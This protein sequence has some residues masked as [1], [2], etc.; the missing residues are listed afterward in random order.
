MTQTSRGAL[1][2]VAVS[3]RDHSSGPPDAPVTLVEYGDFEC[4]FCGMAYPDI[5]RIQSR[6]GDQLRFVYR[7]FPRPEH[8]HARNAAEAAEAAAAQGSQYFWA[9]HD[10]LFE[11]Q[12]ALDDSSLLTHASRIGLDIDRFR[13]DFTSHAYRE[14]VREDLVS[15]VA[16]DV[17]GTPTFFINGQR[18][19]GRARAD[20][21]YRALLVHLDD[22]APADLVDEASAEPFSAG[23]APGWIREKI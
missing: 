1:L 13:A 17:H 6:L 11:K 19:E 7:H 23:D 4:P 9:M 16:S 18:Y 10:Q 2:A 3:E 20:D 5:K 14:R 8:P 12:R 21:L 22:A 15:A